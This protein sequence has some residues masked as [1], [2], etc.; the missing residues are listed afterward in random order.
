LYHEK[1]K[2]T[3]NQIIIKIPDE[4]WDEIH[5][6][7]PKEAISKTVN[8]PIAPFRKVFDGILDILRTGCQWKMLLPQEYGS[9]LYVRQFQEWIQ[10][11]IFKRCG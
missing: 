3:D 10:I 11:D 2:G 4:L 5:N 9:G 7:L 8:R 6:I 1:K